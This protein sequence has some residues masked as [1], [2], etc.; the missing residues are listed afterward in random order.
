MM[1]LRVTTDISGTT[2]ST[3]SKPTITAGNKLSMALAPDTLLRKRIMATNIGNN[4]RLRLR[5]SWRMML[6]CGNVELS[7][8]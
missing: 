8:S 7:T 4:T 2:D 6:E 1:L 5:A 3:H